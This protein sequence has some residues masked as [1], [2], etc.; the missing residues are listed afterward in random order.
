MVYLASISP[1]TYFVNLTG[2]MNEICSRALSN[3]NLVELGTRLG[4]GAFIEKQPSAN[5]VSP[6]TMSA[7]V[8]AIIGAVYIEGGMPSVSKVCRKLAL[9]PRVKRRHTLPMNTSLSDGEVKQEKR[10]PPKPEK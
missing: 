3:N 10:A 2:T 5:Q 7:T 1:S 6:V 9:M 4:L 8:E